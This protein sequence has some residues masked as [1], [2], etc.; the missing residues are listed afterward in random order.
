MIML[1]MNA[2]SSCFMFPPLNQYLEYNEEL[3]TLLSFIISRCVTQMV[4]LLPVD[5][6]L[7]CSSGGNIQNGS[8]IYLLL[9]PQARSL[10]MR[11]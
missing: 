4:F 8:Y 10:H 1:F 6:S 11:S 7:E 2:S 9:I 5:K 3:W